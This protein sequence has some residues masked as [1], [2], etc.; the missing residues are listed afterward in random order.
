MRPPQGRR[1][2]TQEREDPRLHL[3]ST[4]AAL[5][6]GGLVL[7]SRP[8][9]SDVEWPRDRSDGYF[10]STEAV[11]EDFPCV[12]AGTCRIQRI[13]NVPTCPGMKVVE[14]IRIDNGRLT[15]PDA[16]PECTRQDHWLVRGDGSPPV[17]LV[18]DCLLQDRPRPP[19][20]SATA[21]VGCDLFFRYFEDGDST[22]RI[23][24]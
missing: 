12:P 1:L 23:E 14:T 4:V 20:A 2:Q 6:L 13:R 10:P 11:V 9:A 24:T 17:L 18:T 5:I 3:H 16:G 22:S 7:W 8:S 15:N 21:I 19:G